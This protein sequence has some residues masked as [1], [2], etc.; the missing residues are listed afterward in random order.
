M[1]SLDLPRQLPLKKS[2]NHTK[3]WLLNGILTKILVT[4]NKPP[5]NLDKFPKLMK[6]SQMTAKERHMIHMVLMLQVMELTLISIKQTTFSNTSSE[7][8]DL[9]TMM[10]QISLGAYLEGKARAD[11]E[12]FSHQL[13]MMMTFFLK[14]SEMALE[15]V[16][17]QA[18]FHVLHL[19]MEE[20][21]QNLQVQ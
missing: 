1:K 3:K 13:L 12:D 8:S 19:A 16:S 5:K 2:R 17:V 21:Y 6:S 4:K 11:W 9:I 20:E 18:H 10:T 14:D 15:E 7:I